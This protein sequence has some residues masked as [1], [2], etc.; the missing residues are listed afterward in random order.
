MAW[1]GMSKAPRQK[2]KPESN[3]ASVKFSGLSKDSSCTQCNG[4]PMKGFP[5]KADL[6]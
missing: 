2:G 1:S 3:G 6:I 4:E 5:Y